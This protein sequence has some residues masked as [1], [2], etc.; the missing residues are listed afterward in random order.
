VKNFN[1]RLSFFT[2]STL[3]CVLFF[4]CCFS[5]AQALT[6]I[7]DDITEDTIWDLGESPYIV[8]ND[9]E[10]FPE[11][12]LTILP[13]VVVKFNPESHP[14]IYVSGNLIADGDSNNKIY[15]TSNYDDSVGGDTDGDYFCYDD[16]DEDGNFLGEIC[17]G[18]TL[19]PLADDWGGIIFTNSN[20]SFI[21]NSVFRYA[22]LALELDSS[23]INLENLE[24][25]DSNSGILAD[26][27]S[28]VL[29]TA[30]E[31]HDILYDVLTAFNYS[32][33]SAS[34]INISDIFQYPITIFNASH[35]NISNSLIDGVSNGDVIVVLNGSFLNLENL[36]IKN[37][38]VDDY[39]SVAVIFNNSH[40][41]IKNSSFYNCPEGSCVVF[42]D[43]DE[44]LLNPS[45]VL[46]KDSIFDGGSSSGF[47]SF[48][49]S[50]ISA[51]ISGSTIKNFLG[52][53]IE[54]HSDF[55]IQAENN[56][57]GNDTGPF[58]SILNSSGTAGSI[59]GNVDFIP[60][61]DIED[62]NFHNPVILIPGITGTYLLKDDND[63]NE[64]IWPNLLKLLLP[65]DDSF[66]NYLT[67]EVD[68]TENPDKPVLL[69]DI[70]R[71]AVGVHVFDDLINELIS[72][73][74]TENTN[75]FVF[76]Y[77]WRKSSA[78]NSIA[79]KNKIEEVLI[80]T[81][82][83][84]VDLVAHSMGGLLTKKY[85]R[86]NNEDKIDKLIFLGTPHL[87]APKAFKVLMY[88]D[89][90]GYS[91]LSFGLNPNRAKFISQNMPA[92]YELLPSEKYISNN[93]NYVI[94]AID[95]NNPISLD[96]LGTKDLMIE[97]GR[98]SLMFP[99]TENLHNNIDDFSFSNLDTYNFVG[100]GTKTIGEITTRRKRSWTHLGLTWEDDYDLKYVNGDETVPLVSASEI[101][102][103]NKYFAKNITHGSLP[104]GDGV[105][106]DI[107]A[108]LKEETLPTSPNILTDVS[109]CK[110][111]G[112]VV[113][114]HS[115]VELHIYDETGNHTGPDINGDI[116]QNI[117]EVQYDII[118]GEKFV[119]LPDGLNYKITTKATDVGGYNFEIKNEDQNDNI[120]D[121]Y[122]WTLIP[123]ET[124][125]A[126]GEIWIGP[127]YSSSEY[128]IK[129][130]Q[131]GNGNID[132]NFSTSYDGTTFAEET[133]NLST[134]N[135]SS[136]S[137][138][139]QQKIE[140]I[141]K[142]DKTLPEGDFLNK[143]NK[144][145]ENISKNMNENTLTEN[146]SINSK[147]TMPLIASV[148]SSGIKINKIWFII[149]GVGFIV[150]I[151]AKKFIKV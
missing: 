126:Q 14:L 97:K 69:G 34:N 18:S 92:V 26:E 96:Y 70:I 150:G 151:L 121:T 16:F 98:N 68:G 31:F 67:L 44:Y 110:V 90:M 11:K 47:F 24:I 124:L 58:H 133:T 35:L 55:V 103:N 33:I 129:M 106:E 118:E 23:N 51:N 99:F 12:I 127:D 149:I 3:C 59:S 139:Y 61:C 141:V 50:N 19:V 114:A 134:D 89:S 1:K 140:P 27:N 22:D 53:A 86:D 21:K 76:S 29:I 78:E 142:L 42:F 54:N 123:L 116:E 37:I 72:N 60:W 8:Q 119:F 41:S 79:L 20:N 75:L 88:G 130:D 77:D 32:S 115:P 9:I 64:E 122:N 2:L 13:G 6:F 57:W 38:F 48:G 112:K 43:G 45:S 107:T 117:P 100:C 132:Q 95:K 101:L 102:T 74:Y 138:I 128:V 137:I 49:D 71:G 65:G 7:T 46:V 125:Q 66:L 143:T 113:S 39:D 131:D 40:L 17:D 85:I 144:K 36:E 105:R 93:G 15:F 81:G 63:E 56:F 109:T 136:G 80:E 146:S 4:F 91:K 52:F 82:A 145:N 10:I 5:S 104:S 120:T 94:N 111:S 83:E 87:G 84:K 30:G 148:N 73:G 62:C 28:N 25:S 147:K 135:H 108:I